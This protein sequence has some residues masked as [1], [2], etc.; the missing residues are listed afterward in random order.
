MSSI[1]IGFFFFFQQASQ[2]SVH[3]HNRQIA[4]CSNG[5]IWNRTYGGAA[6]KDGKRCY[7]DKCRGAGGEAGSFVQ[8][9]C[10]FA[11]L[12][13]QFALSRKPLSRC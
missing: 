9:L 8:E 6:G 7:L 5:L 1:Q 4:V 2:A 10:L 3:S 12:Y 13:F 11:H